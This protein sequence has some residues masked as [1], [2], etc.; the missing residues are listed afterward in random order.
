MAPY[1]RK[2]EKVYKSFDKGSFLN[3]LKEQSNEDEDNELNN[4]ENKKEIEKSKPTWN[5][6][7]D[8]YVMNAKMENWDKEEGEDSEENEE[9]IISNNNDDDLDS[10]DGE[11]DTKPKRMKALS[12]DKK[13]KF[14]NKNNKR[15]KR[16]K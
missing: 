7:R 5:V 12:K 16:L 8:E 13:K 9:E 6:L 4:T 11:L 14:Q 15:S 1:E 2:I 10:M 3:R